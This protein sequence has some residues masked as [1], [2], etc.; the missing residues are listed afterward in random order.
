MT[1][2]SLAWSRDRAIRA[3]GIASGATDHWPPP[4]W[5]DVFMDA[6]EAA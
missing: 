1:A 4:G 5:L 6:Y 3:A 2:T